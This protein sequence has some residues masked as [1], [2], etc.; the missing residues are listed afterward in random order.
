MNHGNTAV[1]Y[2]V[3]QHFM[4]KIEIFCHFLGFTSCHQQCQKVRIVRIKLSSKV[5]FSAKK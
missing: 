1:R 3:T 5:P 4:K 2:S